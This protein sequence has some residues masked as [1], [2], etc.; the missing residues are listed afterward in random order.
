LL[1]YRLLIFER[2]GDGAFRTPRDYPRPALA[3]ITTHDLPTFRGWWRGLDIDL[4][5]SVGLYDQDMAAEQKRA[6]AADKQALAAALAAEGLLAAA[7]PPE[8]PPFE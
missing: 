8:E 1:S 6:R 7:E 4:R 2:G 3:A 5:H